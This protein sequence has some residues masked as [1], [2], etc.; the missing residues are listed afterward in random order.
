MEP[1]KTQQVDEEAR[2]L[3]KGLARAARFGA[4]ATL[5]PETGAPAASRTSLA[6]L[7]DGR[8]VFL[9]SRLSAHFG[10][11]E[12]DPRASLLVGEPGGGDPLKHPRLAIAGAA[13]MLE[14]EERE[15]AR[16]RFV[17]R[18]GYAALYEGFADFAYWSLRPDRGTLVGGFA[19]AYRL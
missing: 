2:R 7:I 19:R 18:H 6:T 12:A 15:A 4:L 5:D 3:A 11:L 17:A 14:G 9:I 1:D 13:S 10:A 8:P 16:R